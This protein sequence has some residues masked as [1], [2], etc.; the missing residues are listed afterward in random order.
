MSRRRSGSVTERAGSQPWEGGGGGRGRSP[1]QYDRVCTCVWWWWWGEGAR[2]DAPFAGGAPKASARGRGPAPARLAAAPTPLAPVRRTSIAALAI[3]SG[4][5]GG[6]RHPYPRSSRWPAQTRR[7]TPG[8]RQPRRRQR[9]RGPVPLA[10]V[11]PNPC[12]R[13]CRRARP[14]TRSL[15]PSCGAR[16]RPL[17]TRRP[18]RAHIVGPVLPPRGGT[19]T[20]RRGRN[21]PYTATAVHRP[22]R[23]AFRARCDAARPSKPAVHSLQPCFERAGAPPAPPGW[24]QGGDV[25][26]SHAGGR[27]DALPGPL[28][29]PARFLFAARYEAQTASALIGQAVTA[30]L[31]YPSGWSDRGCQAE[32]EAAAPLLRLSVV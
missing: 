19:G 30:L 8:R 16:R 4:V 13:S 1:G 29:A 18:A 5:K 24:G 15:G 26:R 7:R 31:S 17:Q 11:R 10:R 6:G 28:A 32:S 2:R 23:Y 21:G 14:S 12:R 3:V 20:L 25:A 22:L 9:P 27:R